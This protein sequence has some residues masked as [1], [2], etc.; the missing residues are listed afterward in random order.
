MKKRD[1]STNDKFIEELILGLFLRG[2][3]LL[4]KGK[5][6]NYNS[7]QVVIFDKSDKIKVNLSSDSKIYNLPNNS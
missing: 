4:N 7:E 5:G 3:I 2:R 1:C 6:E